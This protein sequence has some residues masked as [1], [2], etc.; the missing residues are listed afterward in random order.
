MPR[1]E[2]LDIQLC[3]GAQHPVNLTGA[4]HTSETPN[5]TIKSLTMQSMILGFSMLK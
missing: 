2:V 1:Q 5:K 4:W 3:S